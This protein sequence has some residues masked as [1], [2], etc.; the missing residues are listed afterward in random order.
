[1]DSRGASLVE[2]EQAT[3]LFASADRADGRGRIG[4]GEGDDVAQALVVALGVVVRHK[5]AEHVAQMTFAKGNN[6]PEALVLD[7]PNEP[8]GVGVQVRAPRRQAQ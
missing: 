5:V 6:V 4:G 7:G 8:L 2:G 3:E 1:M